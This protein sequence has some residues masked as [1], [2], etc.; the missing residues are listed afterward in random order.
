MRSELYADS[1]DEWKWSV[2]IRHARQ[3]SQTIFWVVMLRPNVGEHGKDRQPVGDALQ[4]VTDFFSEER[5]SHDE[6]KPKELSNVSRLCSQMG[7]SLVAEMALYPASLAQRGNY[8]DGVV[9]AL[10]AESQYR[11]FVLLDPDNGIGESSRRGEQVHVAHLK[12]IWRALGDGDTL[13]VVQFQNNIPDWIMSLRTRIAQLLSV[14][15]SHVRSFSWRNV[16]LYL[17]DFATETYE[18]PEAISEDHAGAVPAVRAVPAQI[19]DQCPYCGQ[20]WRNGSF[21]VG[22]DG[23]AEFVCRSVADLPQHERKPAF[24]G[25]MLRD[26]YQLGRKR[27]TVR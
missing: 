9:R 25:M 24:R 18:G 4:E 8:V 2:A 20:V 23:H 11:R 17:V 26:G 10:Q 22:W 12:Q 7:V 6:G 1:R 5:L 19:A 15:L 14:P 13:A 27:R 3:V 21:P 16:C